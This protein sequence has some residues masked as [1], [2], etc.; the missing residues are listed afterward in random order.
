MGVMTRVSDFPA[1]RPR[2]TACL[3]ALAAF[4]AL[5]GVA[6]FLPESRLI[7]A[8]HDDAF[9]YFVVARNV[10]E[11]AGF[12]FDR[13]H[14]TNGFHP[15]WLASIVPVFALLN[16]DA[17]PL[18]AVMAIQIVLVALAV[19][20]VFRA[21]HERLGIGAAA[22]SLAL[23]TLPGSASVLAGGLESSLVLLT[24]VMTWIYFE[25]AV[26]SD[27][28]SLGR[29]L[30]IGCLCAAA[31]LA[32]FEALVLVPVCVVLGRRSLRKEPRRAAMLLA[33]PIVAMVAFIVW[34]RAGFG[35]WLPVSGLVKAEWAARGTPWDRLAKA[36]ELPWAVLARAGIHVAATPAGLILRTVRLS[37]LLVLAWRFRGALGVWTRSSRAGFPLVAGAAW[38]A[39]D[40]V[41]GLTIEPW[42]RVPIYLCTAVLFGACVS[43]RRRVA[44]CVTVLLFVAALGQL[45]WT[46]R[47]LGGHGTTYS[48]YRYQAALWLREKTAENTRVGSWNA[49]LL[50]YFSHRS[51]VNLDGLVNDRRYFEDVIVGRDLDGYLRRERIDWLADQACGV[52]P[53]LRP[54]L[55]PT[56]SESIETEFVP[57]TVFADEST[58]DRCPG[59]AVWR[60]RQATQML[61]SSEN[62]CRSM[63][64]PE[65]IATIGPRP[66]LPVRAAASGRAPAPSEMTRDFSA[67][68]R[69][70]RRV[71]SRV[72]TIEPSM[73]G[74]MRS[75]MRGKTLCPPAPSTND[76]FQSLKACGD[77]AASDSATGAAVSG[78][79]PQILMSGLSAFRALPTPVIS[80]PP[81]IAAMTAVVSGASSRISSPMVPWPA[82][83][84]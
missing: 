55:R 3:L 7:A 11:G 22:A 79:A 43:V 50:G 69:I 63:F 17:L 26:D 81:P 56:A 62:F 10:A 41:A 37:A 29:W 80:P 38:V 30:A 27:E 12:T 77:P 40:M 73:S 70:A 34:N 60:R 48:T 6:L 76:A 54:Y 82:M 47:T 52:D 14:A 61:I 78:S 68:S 15:L 21:L 66:A 23:V 28:Q 44:A 9:Y 19:V 32:R 65:T 59:F 36:F 84:W 16:G 64:P 31:F 39:L 1:S 67:I 58:P 8:F 18:R 35:T 75:H 72:T 57:V 83:N 49:G 33:P 45:F 4:G 24:F 42:N 71:S 46:A 20:L 51:V 74:F 53:S 13:L 5:R 2:G 25:R